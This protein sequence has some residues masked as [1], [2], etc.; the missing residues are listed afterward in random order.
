MLD[1]QNV[2]AKFQELLAAE[3]PD[4]FSGDFLCANMPEIGPII[5]MLYTW[6]QEDGNL[7][8]AKTHLENF[9]GIGQVLLDTVVESK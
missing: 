1:G 5:L 9:K 3:F 8:R 2:F 6:V 4:E 7:M